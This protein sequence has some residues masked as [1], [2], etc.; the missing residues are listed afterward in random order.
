M[1]RRRFLLLTS[2]VL[3]GGLSNTTASNAFPAAETAEWKL[4][5]EQ[6]DQDSLLAWRFALPE[7][8]ARVLRKSLAGLDVE[9]K[10]QRVEHYWRFS[11]RVSS[12]QPGRACFL[13]LSREYSEQ[14]KPANFN[15][16]VAESDVFRQSPHY[17]TAE[18]RGKHLQP[19]PM[20]A[21]ETPTGVEAAIS[22]TPA[23]YDNLTSQTFDLEARR[24]L[25]AS[26]DRALHWDAATGGFIKARPQ[27]IS[28]TQHAQTIEAHFFP[29]GAGVEHKFEV[30][31]LRFP[32]AELAALRQ[33]VNQVVSQRWSPKPINDLLG[34]TYF[35][36]AYMNLRAN[37][38]Q[39]GRY[40]VVPAIEYAD[41]QYSRDAFWI[42]MMLPPE[43]SRSCFENE[44]ANDREFTG[45]ERQLFTIVWAYRNYLNGFA[46]DKSR[47]ERILRIVE[48]QAPGGYYS[49]FSTRTRVPGRRPRRRNQQ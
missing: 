36:T 9:A 30:V 13:S 47:V 35:A 32:G 38:T 11:A 33:Q 26:G 40:W 1:D 49:G 31:F 21:L 18:Y 46:V 7:K 34:S 45:A 25:L 27:T 37:E 42:S 15:G 28:S 4:F 20:V 23:H 6:P 43:Y 24:V 22:D 44:A 2:A 48:A 17:P 12:G 29:L 16:E 41:H 5:I 39:P 8:G 3:A 10:V 14:C 19:L